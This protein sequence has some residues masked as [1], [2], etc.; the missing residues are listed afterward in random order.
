MSTHNI[1][2][3]K[4]KK[5]II[6]DYHKSANMGS[7]PGTQERVRNSCGKRAINGR[8]IEVLLYLGSRD[9]ENVAA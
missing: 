7:V 3:L 6:L 5:K 4:I 2:F 1:P 8:A 9:L